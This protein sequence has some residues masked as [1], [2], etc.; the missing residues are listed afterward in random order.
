L[1]VCISRDIKGLYKKA[2][3]GELEDFTGI[4]SPYEIP[5]SP[6][7]IINHKIPINENLKDMLNILVSKK[8]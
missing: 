1:E 4:T 6:D 7:L 3:S 8:K 2:M 5:E